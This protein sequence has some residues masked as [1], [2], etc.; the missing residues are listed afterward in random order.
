M[1][2]HWQRRAGGGEGRG[3]TLLPCAPMGKGAGGKAG[4]TSLRLARVGGD[5]PPLCP[6]PTFRVASCLLALVLSDPHQTLK[7]V[8]APPLAPRR[9]PFFPPALA[10]P[11]T[12]CQATTC[13]SRM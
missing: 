6:S 9:A 11:P 4:G 3:D 8:W 12:M 10:Y 7:A 5:K 13:V 1:C 2:P